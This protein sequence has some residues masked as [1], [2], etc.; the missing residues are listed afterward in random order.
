MKT[1]LYSLMRHPIYSFLILSVWITPTMVCLY[2]LLVS[3]VFI[4]LLQTV[5]HLL[6]SVMY[7]GYILVA[8]R[9]YEEPDLVDEFGPEYVEYMKSTPGYVPAI[10]FLTKTKKF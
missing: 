9:F 10:P 4:D 2:R 5:G 6:L 8:V 1:G 7:T 3:V